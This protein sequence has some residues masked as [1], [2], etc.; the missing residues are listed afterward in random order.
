MLGVRTEYKKG[1]LFVRLVGRID[2]EGYLKKINW[3]IEE[4]GIKFTVLNLTKIN[5]ISL[6][7]IEN[8]RNYIINQGTKKRLLLICDENESRNNIINQN[9][10]KIKNEIEAFSIINRKDVYGW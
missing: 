4:L 6:E 1:V 2:N 9:I 10:P 7:N 3:L 8:I 5:N